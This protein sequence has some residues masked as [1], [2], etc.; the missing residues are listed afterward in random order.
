M[1]DLGTPVFY[2]LLY[3]IGVLGALPLSKGLPFWL[4]SITGFIWGK[5]ILV[6]STM[7]L[8]ILG[9][10]Y[11]LLSL[12]TVLAIVTISL[13][14]INLL[15]K[16]FIQPIGNLIQIAL[17]AIATFVIGYFLTRSYYLYATTDS[18][19]I[20]FLSNILTKF[21]LQAFSLSQF[22][23]WGVIS[24]VFQMA[25]SILGLDYMSGYQSILGAILIGLL[26]F[27][28]STVLQREFSKWQA[29]LLGAAAALAMVSIMFIEQAIYIHTNLTAALYI[30]IS[31]YAIWNYLGESKKEWLMIGAAALIGVGFS[32]IEGPLYVV[33]FSAL[34]VSSKEFQLKSALQLVLPYLI[35]SILWN[36]Y[37]FLSVE[38]TGLLNRTN[39]LIIIGSLVGLLGFVLI[40]KRVNH[41]PWL[42]YLI[43]GVLGVGLAGTFL[44]KPNHMIQ[45]LITTLFNLVSRNFWGLTWITIMMLL[46]LAI[47]FSSQDRQNLYMLLCVIGYL[48]MVLAFAFF[49]VPYRMGRTD[50][51]T[52]LIFQIQP[53]IFFYIAANSNRIKEWL[54]LPA[55]SNQ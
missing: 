21:G 29:Y 35:L 45:S 27:S 12:T 47:S 55:K 31:L 49:R 14:V 30:F 10:P 9:M 13:I 11:N 18:F 8:L 52:R 53:L 1:S 37:L 33:L 17:C 16:T 25:S 15:E 23:E 39:I 19:S 50:S 40:S 51:A 28:I 3:L 48:I 6:F 42:S 43:I 46:P 5:L 34:A 44:I 36:S 32:R 24:P 38:E 54:I 41:L 2:L 4:I 20:I 22:T 7:I 26:F